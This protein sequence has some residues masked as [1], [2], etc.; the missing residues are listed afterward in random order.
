MTIIPLKMANSI[1]H[2]EGR[3]VTM[4]EAILFHIPRFST[5]QETSKDGCIIT[6]VLR[7]MIA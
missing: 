2:H 3:C 1:I 5:K 6:E 7:S 4:V